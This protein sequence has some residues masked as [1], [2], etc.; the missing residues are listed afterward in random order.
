MG[1]ALTIRYWIVSLHG[2]SLSGGYLC[3]SE[4]AY[5][6]F[7]ISHLLHRSSLLL[8]VLIYIAPFSNKPTITHHIHVS[9]ISMPLHPISS[10][11][12]SSLLPSLHILWTSHRYYSS[13]KGP[14]DAYSKLF[15]DILIIMMDLPI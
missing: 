12:H 4:D 10:S 5:S 11:S 3:M 14:F 2:H 13:Y 8:I 6:I 15:A 7:V 1:H 9:T